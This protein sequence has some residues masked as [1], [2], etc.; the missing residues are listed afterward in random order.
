MAKALVFGATGQLGRAVID[1]LLDKGWHV[2]AV[3]RSRPEQLEHLKARGVEIIVAENKSH[4]EIINR[5]FET[6]FEPTAYNSND[7][8]SLLKASGKFGCA[9]V[10][11]SCSVYADAEGRSLDEAAVG[12][13]PEFSKPMTEETSTVSA[14]D[15]TYSTRKIAMENIFCNSKREIT[16]LRPCAI[17]G[18]YSTHPREWWLIKRA[19]DGRKYIPIA[20]NAESI[21]HTSSASG[22][23]SLTEICMRS[24]NQ[25]IVNVADP[26]P[27][28]IREIAAAL[29]AVSGLKINLHPFAGKPVGSVGDTPWST[30]LPYILDCSRAKTLGWDGGMEYGDAVKNLVRWLMTFKDNVNWKSQFKSYAN[31]SDD[32]FDY[33]AEDK[34]LSR[35]S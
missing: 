22:I 19:L 33:A 5:P 7:A 10:V 34:W 27:L 13:F 4:S 14:G 18:R 25:R 3:T 35:N 32:P 12:G 15:E 24:P 28:T 9:V 21:F 31:Y 2:T 17:Y 26:K 20:Y 30:P 23:A 6:V 11:S 16:I 29:E 8:K 1:Q